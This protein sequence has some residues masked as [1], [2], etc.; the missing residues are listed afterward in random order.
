[1]SLSFI[2]FSVVSNLLCSVNFTYYVVHSQNFHLTLYFLSS[3]HYVHV[4]IRKLE[5]L[6]YIFHCDFNIIVNSF[7]FGDLYISTDIFHGYMSS[8][9]A[10]S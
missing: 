1:M 3:P 10:S 8:V 6:N 9:P 7:L 5:H 2:F 4:F